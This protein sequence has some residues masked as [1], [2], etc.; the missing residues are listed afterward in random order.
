V[1]GPPNKSLEPERAIVPVAAHLALLDEPQ[2]TWEGVEN[3]RRQEHILRSSGGG[4]VLAE[5]PSKADFIVF[6][7]SNN[8][9]NW[10][11]IPAL[12]QMELVRDYPEKCYTVNYADIPVAFFP[13]VY[14][15]LP[16]AQFREDWARAGAY[17]LGSPNKLIAEYEN[18]PW[19]PAQLFSFRG[20]P[21]HP[22]RERLLGRAAAWGP[23]NPVARVDR[24]FNHNEAELRGYLQEIVES[25]FVLCPR[26]LATN[27]HRLYEVMRLGRVPVI[28]AD[29]W[30]PLAGPEWDS[31]SIRLAENA[32]DRIPS[33]LQKFTAT[34][35]DM[36]RKARAAWERWF[37]PEVILRRQLAEIL[38]L[39]QRR[40]TLPPLDFARLWRSPGFYH[41]H[42]WRWHQRIFCRIRRHLGR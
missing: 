13:G 5:N 12:L 10:R 22:V 3:L 17:Y 15:S 8:F 34:A 26:G 28:L 36:G 2:Q 16:R 9:K 19:N 41:Q 37:S 1:N 38:V 35:P 18:R 39:T 20:A 42:G 23:K 40:R 30:M 29:D 32:V 33:L 27:T 31:F 25:E 24:W 4:F 11:Q 14:S 21:S 7:E 6:L